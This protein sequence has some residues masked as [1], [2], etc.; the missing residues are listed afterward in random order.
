MELWPHQ[1]QGLEGIQDAMDREVRR[2]L[3]TAPT[4][5]GKTEIMFEMVK[6]GF[7]VVFYL[8]RKMLLE[9]FAEKLDQAGYSFGI[10]ASGHKPRLLED[11]QL[12]SVQTDYQRCLVQQNR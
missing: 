1:R 2:I 9:Q 8:H 7:P 12:S 5:G 3:L 4:G 10:R 6:W 11:I